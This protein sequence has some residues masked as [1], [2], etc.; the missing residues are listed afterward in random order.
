MKHRILLPLICLM[1]ITV[2]SQTIYNVCNGDTLSLEVTVPMNVSVQWQQS[3]DSV[4]WYDIPGA[5][6]STCTIAGV[7]NTR[8]YR[9]LFT[10]PVCNPFLSDIKKVNVVLPP[11]A[12]ITNLDPAYCSSGSPVSLV[13]VPA[14]GTFSGS[15][16]SGGI[17][18][19]GV[20]GAGTHQITYTVTNT[21]GCTGSITLVTTVVQP[22]TAANAGPDITASTNTVAM[23]ANTPTS[24]T[25]HWSIASG[26]GGSFANANSSTSNFTGTSNSVYQLVWTIS[27]PPCSS[28]TDTVAV[29]MPTGPTLPFVICGSPSYT[30]YVHP[31]DNAGPMLWGCTGI[32]SGASDQW[33]GAVNTPL[34]IQICGQNTAAWVCDNLV[35]HGYS[36]WYLP[37]YN[38]LDCVRTNA[39][40]IGGFSADKYWSSSEGAGILYL[41]AYYRTFPSGTSGAGGKSST[42]A[43]V[44]C[45][46]KD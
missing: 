43:R 28:S 13:G 16:I 23:A 3:L 27:N 11:V 30:M 14:G 46:R 6:L 22:P 38:E 10:G 15:G 37:A 32:A 26:T 18:S 41:N 25:G 34:I 33:N 12:G 36:D 9:A 44:R 1:A 45:V 2:H 17:F 20:A 7:I 21:Y 39:T 35:A 8:F 42:Q 4:A 40:T 19:P 29:T 31:T 5:V 24:G